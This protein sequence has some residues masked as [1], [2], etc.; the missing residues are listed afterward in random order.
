[1]MVTYLTNL[2]KNLMESLADSDLNEIYQEVR[3]IDSRIYIEAREF[4]IKPHFFS[5]TKK[6][7]NYTMFISNGGEAQIYNFPN[8]SEGS[9]I[10]PYVSRN[11]IYTYLLG[12]LNGH[13]FSK[14]G[15]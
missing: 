5:K 9:S 10:N 15:R 4:K 7:T 14:I 3:K 13:S 2:E 1:M 6:I 12:F 8:I 11:Q